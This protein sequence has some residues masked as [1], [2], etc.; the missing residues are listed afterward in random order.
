MVT[1]PKRADEAWFNAELRSAL[2]AQ[3]LSCA[4][5]RETDQ[6]GFSDLLIWSVAEIVGFV[7]IKIDGAAL[8]VGQREFLRKQDAAAGNAYVFDL[9]RKDG[10]IRMFRGATHTWSTLRMCGME[11]DI[12][13]PWRRWFWEHRREEMRYR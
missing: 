6:P 10:T 5:V 1:V 9:D 3:N 2:R 8:E 13:I 12:N 11:E 7:E 4:H